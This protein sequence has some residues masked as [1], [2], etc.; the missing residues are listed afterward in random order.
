MQRSKEVAND[1]YEHAPSDK[2]GKRV[3][4]AAAELLG[5]LAQRDDD[6]AEKW[7]RRGD[8]NSP[9]VKIS[10]LELEARKVQRQGKHA[11]CAAKY[12]EVASQWFA[13]GGPADVAGFN[14]AAVAYERQFA[15]NGDLS[16]LGRAEATLDKA[17]RARPDDP[18]VTGNL[19]NMLDNIAHVRVLAKR[20]DLKALQIDFSDA[21]LLMA[22]LLDNSPERDAVLGDLVAEPAERRSLDLFAQYEV[23]APSS[24]QAYQA[25]FDQAEQRRDVA[26]ATSVVERIQR[27]KALDTSEIVASRDR[28]RSGSEDA[29]LIEE[30][31]ADL[32][33]IEQALARKLDPRT[34]AAAKY[35]EATVCARLG[36]YKRDPAMLERS[37]E[38]ARAVISGWPALDTNGYIV[39]ALVDQAGLAAD[40]DAWRQLRRLR[41]AYAALAKAPAAL[42]DKIKASPQWREV[43]P[44]AKADPHRPTINDVRL[45]RFLGDAEL[46]KRV[47]VVFDD[48]LAKLSFELAVVMK[49]E[50]ATED[51]AFITKR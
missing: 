39:A 21:R 19:A 37:R 17:Y 36:L 31:Q 49:D 28:W 20:I 6:E 46:E 27:T 7:F 16:A 23:L 5:L 3:Q 50:I 33:R 29:K 43:A 24:P 26:A 41:S 32:A 48:P 42:A 10:L 45:A 2:D 11:E 4:E 44:H 51:L 34:K 14:N 13:T 38:A 1:V 35:L 8:R 40:A 22:E 15:C 18:I 12:G 47:S 25:Q 9:F 30:A